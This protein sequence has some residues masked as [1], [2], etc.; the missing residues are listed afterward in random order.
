MNKK[1]I[2]FLIVFF[3][4]SINHGQ[5]PFVKLEFDEVKMFEFHGGKGG[6]MSIIDAS[7]N[8]AKTITNQTV[9]DKEIILKLNKKFL[10]QNSRIC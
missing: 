1:L 3:S 6:D 2:V 9:L 4:I 7:G 10:T 8:M 5:N